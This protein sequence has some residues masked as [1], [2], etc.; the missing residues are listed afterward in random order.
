MWLVGNA[1]PEQD[2]AEAEARKAAAIRFFKLKVG[3]K[4]LATEVAAA[5]RRARSNRTGN[6]A[7]RRRQLRVL[8]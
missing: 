4:P 8:P 5:L 6:A 3:V 2:V 1:T 7:V